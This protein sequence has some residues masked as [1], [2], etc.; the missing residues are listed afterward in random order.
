MKI[1]ALVT[2]FMTTRAPGW[3]VLDQPEVLECAVSAARFYAGYGDIQSIS[4]SDTLPGAPEPSAGPG[5]IGYLA[6]LPVAVEPVIAPAL[7]IKSLGYVTDQTT[8]STG[9]WALI[10]PLFVLYTERE[11]A[12]RLE[13]SRA[14]GL[15]VYGRMVSEISSD[16]ERMESPE[17]LPAKA[18]S[19]VIIGV[20]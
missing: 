12:M 7:P 11:N 1:E 18:F 20:Y 3:L 5:D 17:G 8:L 19:H 4:L 14:L 2:E 10:R 13:A 6:P 9:E 15:E 16:I